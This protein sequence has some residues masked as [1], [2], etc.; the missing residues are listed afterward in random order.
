MCPNCNGNSDA[1][2]VVNTVINN[3][4]GVPYGMM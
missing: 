4:A 1:A 3:L 2:T